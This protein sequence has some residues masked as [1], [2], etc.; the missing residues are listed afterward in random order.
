[1]FPDYT[2]LDIQNAADNKAVTSIL[3]WLPGIPRRNVQGR[4]PR[5][6]PAGQNRR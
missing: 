1:M 6:F 5:L 3:D 4:R 2:H